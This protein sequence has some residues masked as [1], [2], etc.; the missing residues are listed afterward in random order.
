MPHT[1]PELPEPSMPAIV[2]EDDDDSVPETSQPDWVSA[3]EDDAA[4]KIKTERLKLIKA[5]IME[6]PVEDAIDAEKL[7][8]RVDED[9]I[10]SIQKF[11]ELAVTINK[12]DKAGINCYNI[13][14][15]CFDEL[16]Q[17]NEW[18]CNGTF[19]KINGSNEE[20][21]YHVYKNLYGFMFASLG[22]QE[23]DKTCM[24]KLFFHYDLALF[25]HHDFKTKWT[26]A[27]IA[28]NEEHKHIHG[29]YNWN[30]MTFLQSLL[31]QTEYLLQEEVAIDNARGRHRG[32]KSYEGVRT[33]M[34]EIDFNTVM[35]DWEKRVKNDE[36]AT[37]LPK[38]EVPDSETDDIDND[39]KA[40]EANEA[41][42]ANKTRPNVSQTEISRR[43][44]EYR[45]RMAL[46][47]NNVNAAWRPLVVQTPT[48]WYIASQSC[49]DAMWAPL[50]LAL[51]TYDFGSFT[52][53]RISKSGEEWQDL[54]PLAHRITL[55]D[56]TTSPKFLTSVLE[57]LNESLETID[58][59]RHE[60]SVM[61]I[62]SYSR[63][64]QRAIG[65]ALV[66]VKRLFYRWHM[67]V[68]YEEVFRAAIP[69]KEKFELYAQNLEEALFELTYWYRLVACY[70]VVQDLDQHDL[71]WDDTKNVVDTGV[72]RWELE[73][74]SLVSITRMGRP[75]VAKIYILVNPLTKPEFSEEYAHHMHDLC[76]QAYKELRVLLRL[77]ATEWHE[78][79]RFYELR[80]LAY[81]LDLRQKFQ[82][83]TEVVMKQYQRR[84]WNKDLKRKETLTA[85][86]PDKFVQKNW[87]GISFFHSIHEEASQNINDRHEKGYK[88][89]DT[90]IFPG[91]VCFSRRHIKKI[92]YLKTCL[93]RVLYM[94]TY[95]QIPDP[96]EC[97][98]LVEHAIVATS[99]YLE[100]FV[101]IYALERSESHS[102]DYK[103]ANWKW[104]CE[105]EL[106]IPEPRI[107]AEKFTV[108][109]T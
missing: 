43:Q 66:C 15:K 69:D 19:N 67:D 61:G 10:S 65:F 46:V 2:E 75:E 39:Q 17:V 16:L 73:T 83:G 78:K 44:I 72:T 27:I 26:A 101:I 71:H 37:F 33:D 95:Q 79:A 14:E 82:Y 11:K 97:R 107:H 25:E 50:V 77:K 93:K 86:W 64:Y 81:L 24:D 51:Q 22:I 102:L 103:N 58:A 91:K 42:E 68:Q 85:R 32:N 45:T 57:T 63:A 7:K 80:V 49:F 8:K 90:G 47:I 108:W 36:V 56:G 98:D 88:A 100:L 105:A 62:N 94:M 59:V 74:P 106:K 28:E 18:L 109:G 30:N 87:N 96:Y 31:I 99:V 20:N 104:K 54:Q 1:V 21:L 48:D 41:N 76:A 6:L 70:R 55:Q 12:N 60:T 53:P 34:C 92:R 13:M 29:E 89:P 40:N 52:T 23:P 3:P 5:F 84:Q 4:L 9:F 35:I 38:N